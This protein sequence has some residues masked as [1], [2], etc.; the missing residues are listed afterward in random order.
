M[1]V[2]SNPVRVHSFKTLR[3]DRSQGRITPESPER[4][5]AGG[6]LACLPSDEQAAAGRS[7]LPS[8]GEVT[9]ELAGLHSSPL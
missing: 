4:L 8:D 7:C 5:E 9:G 1:L 3:D 2:Q 6:D